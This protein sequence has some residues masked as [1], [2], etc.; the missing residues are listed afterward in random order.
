MNDISTILPE[1]GV[2]GLQLG[3]SRDE[4]IAYFGEADETTTDSN[5]GVEVLRWKKGIECVF[6]QEMKWRLKSISIAHSDAILAEQKII[7]RSQDQVL[8]SLS[9]DFGEPELSNQ[10][11]K[12]NQASYW[13]ADYED[14]G[15]SLWFENSVLSAISVGVHTLDSHNGTPIPEANA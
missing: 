5:N 7:G 11:E 12:I 14:V 1:K 15:M 13:M 3:A 6:D 8:A 9:G 4:A 2:G 10:S